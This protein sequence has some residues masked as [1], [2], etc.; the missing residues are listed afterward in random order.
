MVLPKNINMSRKDHA[1][2]HIW[3]GDDESQRMAIFQNA[4]SVRGD[5]SHGPRKPPSIHPRT[6]MGLNPEPESCISLTQF[7]EPG[8][9]R[10]AIQELDF[11]SAP[12]PKVTKSRRRIEYK[13]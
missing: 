3:A 1:Q 5:Q 9:N 7:R 6:P 12:I 2:I 8:Q 11:P 4:V 10:N 13:Q